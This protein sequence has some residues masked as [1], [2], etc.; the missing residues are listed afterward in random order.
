MHLAGDTPPSMAVVPQV[1]MVLTLP[2]GGGGR[3]GGGWRWIRRRRRRWWR[4]RDGAAR[5]A[6][7]VARGRARLR[8]GDRRGERPTRR[9]PVRPTDLTLEALEPVVN[10]TMPV[11]IAGTTAANIRDI[12]AFADSAEDPADHPRRPRCAAGCRPAQGEE[13]PGAAHRRARPAGS[14]GRSVRREL[15]A[16]GQARG[17]GGALRDH[18]RRRDARHARPALRRGRGGRVRPQPRR[19]AQEP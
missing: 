6:Q 2:G 11:L 4:R 16:A 9:C 5:L 15:H 3:G 17:G 8:Q 10:G 18:L 1:A 19:C 13:R 12:I 7:A 14:R